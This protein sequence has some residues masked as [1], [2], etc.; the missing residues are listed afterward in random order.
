M[1]AC[2]QSEGKSED[3]HE[4]INSSGIHWGKSEVRP[5]S[6]GTQICPYWD[7]NSISD[8]SEI[9]AGSIFIFYLKVLDSS[10][11]QSLIS[12]NLWN[13][14]LMPLDS[15]TSPVRNEAGAVKSELNPVSIE[16]IWVSDV[17]TIS[18]K[19]EGLLNGH[20]PMVCALISR[21]RLLWR[22]G[23]DDWSR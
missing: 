8:W 5:N 11:S 14:G 4:C 15:K 9:L 21:L 22:C 19:L 6:N 1:R 2:V 16:Q 13:S 7:L 3:C 12:Y 20:H 23:A 17:S 18:M 10:G